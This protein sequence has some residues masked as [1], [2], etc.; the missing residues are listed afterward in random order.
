MSIKTLG[1]GLM[2][3]T[4]LALAAPTLVL[5]QTSPG[6]YTTGYRYDAK[7]QLVGLISPDPD[8]GGSLLYRATR[9]TYDAAG[10]LTKVETGTLSAWQSEAVAPSSWSGFTVLK[11]VD[12]VPDAMGRKIR[13]TASAGGTAY[14][15][16]QYSYDV[17]GQLE[18][19]AVRMNTAQFS[20]GTAA[21]SLGPQ[22]P[23]GPDRITRNEY[24]A[25]GA[26]KKVTSG[27][28]V[29][30]M[31]LRENTYTNN[32]LL[33]T[34]TDG[35][36]NTT[37]HEYDAFD[38]LKRTYYPSP[39]AHANTHNP[40]DYQE[41]GYDNNGNVTSLRRR[42]GST[43]TATFDAQNRQITK[44]VPATSGVAAASFSYDYD[45]LGNK[46]SASE[47][48]RTVTR[49]Y[50][51]F[52]RLTSETGPIG[53]VSYHYDAGGR[54]D[55][56]TWPDSFN[57]TYEY[58]NVDS[59]KFI[60]RAGSASASDK[61]AELT[62]DNLG[63]RTGLLRGNNVTTA[64]GYDAAL[65]LQSL[66]QTTANAADNVTYGFQYNPASQI[67]LRTISNSAYVIASPTPVD[68]AYGANGLNQM[69]SAGATSISYDGRGN[70]LSDGVTTWVYD[71]ENRLRGNTAGASHLYDPL[72][73]LYQTTTGSGTVTR[74]LYDDV[75]IIG[76]YNSSNGL[77]RRYVHGPEEDEPLARY[78]GSGTSAEWLLADYQGSIIAT[79][80]NVGVVTVKDVYDEYGAPGGGNDGL[81]Q[82]TGQIFLADLSL[83]HYKARAYSPFYGR[84]LQVDPTGYDDGLSWY[85]YV[86]NDPINKYDPN[87]LAEV[88]PVIVPGISPEELLRRSMEREAMAAAKLAMNT[89]NT[90]V[91][92]VTV[93]AK[94][95]ISGVANSMSAA[96]MC[97]VATIELVAGAVGEIKGMS[98]DIEGAGSIDFGSARV[99]FDLLRGKFSGRATQG[100]DFSF[101][102]GGATLLGGK[103][104]REAT[105]GKGGSKKFAWQLGRDP[106]VGM[107][108]G[109]AL[110]LGGELKAGYDL[111]TPGQKCPK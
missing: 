47:G 109:G 93:T 42:D 97:P 30:A 37:R 75:D 16:T 89:V 4:M 92:A 50:D 73:R 12:I 62:Y 53:A 10:R 52:G 34:E 48:G 82:Y 21:C 56:L 66:S 68:R 28:G 94:K 9:N 61:I 11:Q 103:I 100:V 27:Y 108:V 29:Q 64:Y 107:K 40:S 59:L 5:A 78:V 102:S 69:T 58:D 95:A 36:Q 84:F 105:L 46:I 80:N 15:L 60:R 96:G 1:A 91:E 49:A 101:S 63:R 106:F 38:R 19:A 22:G 85:A 67:T 44:S 81:F 51:G 26:L 35:E 13:E 33:L 74:Y 87:G 111:V 65:R 20:Q 45:N 98:H 39:T 104:Q 3:T 54:R 41:Y 55:Q 32:G 17:F 18:C 88:G 14:A 86:G 71:A 6:A 72:G 25:D 83:Y 99:A 70:L 90:T 8:G 79:T 7:R 110:V 77:L 23:Q 31:V 2:A 76:E 57:V 43:I 24:F